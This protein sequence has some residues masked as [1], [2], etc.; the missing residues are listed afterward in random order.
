MLN[1]I[2]GRT[3]SKSKTPMISLLV[4]VSERALP[5]RLGSSSRFNLAC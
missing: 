1:V 5:R 4:S 2:A 3:I